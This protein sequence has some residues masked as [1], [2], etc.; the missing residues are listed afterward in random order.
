MD[1]RLYLFFLFLSFTLLLVASFLLFTSQISKKK[2]VFFMLSLNLF[3]IVL[4]YSGFEAYFRYRF[5][6]SDSLGFLQVNGRWLERHVVYNNYFFRDRNFESMKKNGTIRIGVLGDSIAMG[7]GIKD[8]H[9]RFSNVLEKK[10]QSEELN[11]E[12]YNLGKSGYD[13]EAEIE[14]YHK[15]KKLQFDWIVWEY[16]LNDAQPRD[17]STGTG[18]LQKDSVQGKIAHFLSSQSFVF[19]FV[20][21]K[22]SARYDK[23]FVD[24]RNA[25]M[26]AYRDEENFQRHK[27]D[28]E[29][30]IR[31]LKTDRVKTLV[32]IFPFMRFL[33]NYP[34]ED[35]HRTM[36]AIFHDN[37]VETVDMLDS[38]RG[39]NSNDLVASQFDYHPNEYVNMLA[40]EILNDSLKEELK[41]IAH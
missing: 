12:V 41:K 20:Y 10:L 11:V 29:S 27:K 35:I 16:F 1:F 33:P 38:L 30:F 18:V 15:V 36:N 34:A 40:A 7:Y 9:N 21:W 31:E 28:V 6:E 17:K 32:I 4:V 13:T 8:V 3:S 23:A 5:D 19:D 25:D 37:E 26:A 24:L 39:K 14:E 2:R 22:L